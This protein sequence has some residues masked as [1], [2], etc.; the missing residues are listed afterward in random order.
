MS[1]TYKVT[2]KIKTTMIANGEFSNNQLDERRTMISVTDDLGEIFTD[3]Y[4]LHR[5][6]SMIG[7]EVLSVEVWEESTI[8]ELE[9]LLV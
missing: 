8:A 1:Y 2:Y 9:L 7:L 6:D 4:H 3:L 5:E